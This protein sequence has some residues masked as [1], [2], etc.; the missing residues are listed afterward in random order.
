MDFLEVI[1]LRTYFFTHWGTVKAVDGISFR[2]KEGEA[3]ALLGESGCGKSITCLSILRLVPEP[4]GRIVGGE[5]F[6]QGEDLLKKSEKEMRI[7]RGRK[8]SMILQDPMT[9]LDPIFTIGD[10]V[11]EAIKIHHRGLK[12]RYLWEKAKKM[13]EMVRIPSPEIRLKSWPHQLSGGMRQRVVGAISLSCEPRLLI[14]DEP[15]T[16]LDA[17]IQIQYLRLLREIQEHTG[18]TLIFVTHDFGI[19]ARICQRAAVMYA[20]KIVEDADVRELFNHPAHP[21]TQALMKS[22]P[23]VEEKVKMLASIEG[24]P[25]PLHK[26][27][28]GCPFAPRC[29]YSKDECRS[30]YPPMV[31]LNKNHFVSCWNLSLLS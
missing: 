27:P 28:P 23:K 8:I 20:G 14:A 29:S 6:L 30:E 15:T 3:F 16:S 4:T 5:I 10:Q 21:Y 18:L 13:L 17:T 2:V 11:T 19:V 25:P 9:S 7:I 22:V 26:L 31:E 12:R 1:N 24:Q